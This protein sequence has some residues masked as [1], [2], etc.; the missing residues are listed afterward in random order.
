MLGKLLRI[1]GT[2]NERELKKLCPIVDEINRIYETLHKLSDEELR[3]KTDEFRERIERNEKKYKSQIDT[4]EDAIKNAI[5]P[6]EKAKVKQKLKDFMN[7]NVYNDVLPEAYAVVKDVC[8]R[9]VDKKWKVCDIEMEW[10]MIP[11][12]VQLMGAIVLHQ[13]KIAEMATGEGK[14]LA[15]TMPLYL[16]ALSKKGAHLVTVND[17]LARRDREWMGP[18]YEFLGLSVGSIQQGMDSEE[19][20][21]QYN[22]DITYG[23]NNEFGFDYLRDNMVSNKAYKVQR[24]HNY[25]IA[26]EVDSVLIDEART[27]LIISGPVEHSHHKFDKFKPLV[28]RVVHSQT[29][30]V[31]NLVAEAEHLLNEDKEYEAGIKLL[32]ARRGTPKNKKLLKLEKER[33]VKKL[34]EQV[35]VNY[36][37]DKKLHELDEDLL[38]SIDERSNVIDITE[39]GRKALSPDN[40]ERFVLPDLSLELHKVDEDTTISVEK[41]LK[42]KD[43]IH[44]NFAE[45]TEEIHNIRQLLKAYSLFEKDDEY[46]VQDER[47]IIV[48]EFTG[49]LMPGRRFSDG[50]HQALEAKEGVNIEK[51]TQTLATIT[52]QNYVRMY[53]KLAGMTGTAETEAAE[54]WEIYKLDVVVMPTNEPVRRLNYP[55]VIYRTRRE[56]YN[57]A[58]DEIEK[59]YREGRPILVGTVSVDVSETISR[60]LKRRGIPHEVLNAKH[61]QR[62]AEIVS[63][64][65]QKSKVT[66][67]TNMAGRGTDIKLGK[68]IV[69]CNR[70][71]IL[72]KDDCSRCEKK[73]RMDECLIEVT[74]GLHII[75]TERHEAR[76]IDRQLRG[77]SARQGDPGSS[78]FY[79]SLEDN[80]MRIFGSDR[81]ASIMDRVGVE[82]GEPIKHPLITKAIEN[83]QKRVE[84]YNFDI[85]K[86]LL[87][88]D[89]VMNRQ[90]EVI[91]ELR[92]EV[93]DG[94]NLKPRI[95]EM[96]EDK[97]DE[98]MESYID[99]KLEPEEWDW[100]SLRG[101]LQKIFLFDLTIEKDELHK[102]KDDNL[103]EKIMQLAKFVYARKEEEVGSDR[104][105]ELERMVM[106]HTIDTKWREHLYGLDSLREGIGLRGY[107]GRDPLIEYKKESFEMFSDLQRS[108]NE[109]VIRYILGLQIGPTPEQRAKY[110]AYKPAVQRART[111]QQGREAT[112]QKPVRVGKKVGRNESCPCGSG[113]KYKKCCGR[114][115]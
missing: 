20:K 101:E 64:A 22:C 105:R 33:G 23:T 71:C 56:K 40:S 98:L 95:E 73:K 51:E 93:L 34:I 54:F 11:F 6:E 112:V 17:Y 108:I 79:L 107:G 41:K 88:Y 52:L 48:D 110:R 67:S 44:K 70:C 92:N 26:D 36:M 74:C 115:Q 109:D 62:E 113:K 78:R 3:A 106:L 87:E 96:M 16:N 37:R 13:G 25:V 86:R 12:D 14:T 8:R 45:K 58:L 89:D 50:L 10:N 15:A 49:R 76:R 104:M 42:L 103:W 27:P 60:L 77:R 63:L 19:R 21:I 28:E 83:A 1:F 35:E 7:N 5:T 99:P 43:E 4:L 38:F 59:L 111:Y 68:D 31:N 46:V 100:E 90:R 94:E 69:T 72:C 29:V 57:A 81:I 2:K 53:N 39:K 82:D 85:R 30:T 91:Y 66:I 80:L 9:L 24:E 102:L 65:G 55:D 61:H 75:G 18:I 32:Q 97:I 84:G 47:V 114:V